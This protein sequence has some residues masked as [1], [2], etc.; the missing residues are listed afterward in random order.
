MPDGLAPALSLSMPH[1]AAA[2]RG[3]P[4]TWRLA[5]PL[6]GGTSV[7]LWVLIARALH[8]LLA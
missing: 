4:L 5:I 1:A 2:E 6:I 7:G 3:A 8:A